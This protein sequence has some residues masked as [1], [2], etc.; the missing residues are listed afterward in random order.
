MTSF[1]HL[2]FVCNMEYPEGSGLLCTFLQRWVAKLDEY[3]TTADRSKKDHVAKGDK[4]G[5]SFSKVFDDYA[6]KLFILSRAAK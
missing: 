2:C 1:L 5:R 4:A 3:G 6:R